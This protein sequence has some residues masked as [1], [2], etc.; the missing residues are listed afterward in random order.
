MKLSPKPYKINKGAWCYEDKRGIEII[1]EIRGEDG[2]YIRT[3]HLLI[4][5]KKILSSVRRYKQE[6][7]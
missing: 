6:D 7:K 3:D 5:W 1:H 2:G 4:P